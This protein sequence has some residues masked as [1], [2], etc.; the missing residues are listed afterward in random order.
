MNPPATLT[1]D[2][3]R[4]IVTRW[5][6]RSLF[7]VAIYALLLFGSAGRLSWGWG[8]VFLAVLAALAFAPPLFLAPRH[9]DLLVEREKSLW[10]PGAK[11]WDRLISTIAGAL[12][13]A[14]WIT[15][16]LDVRLGWSGGLPLPA[17]LAGL[18]VTCAGYALFLWAMASNA[19]FASVVRIQTD[20]GHQVQSGGPYRAIRHPGY[21][22]TMLA[23][24]A[25]PFLLGSWWAL[26]PAV[27]SVGLFV[28]RT[29][30]E[31]RTLLA[32]LP[33]YQEFAHRTRFRIL[34]GVW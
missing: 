1:P 29:R 4:R 5:T 22:G 23:M 14:E 24:L 12:M 25:T 17:H 20:R 10:Q 2:A 11:G 7:G 9:P 21:A 31:D 27:L 26:V 13:L 28:L 6:V 30:L 8:W 3:T 33:G 19:Y 15:A 16:G 18:L 34:P 32:E